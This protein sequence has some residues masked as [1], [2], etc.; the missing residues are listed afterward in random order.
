MRTV[1]PVD[2]SFAQDLLNQHG[3]EN[4]VFDENMSVLEGSIGAFISRRLMVIDEDHERAKDLLKGEGI[5]PYD[6]KPW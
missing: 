3:I 4:F 1:N 2:L 6:G 5:E